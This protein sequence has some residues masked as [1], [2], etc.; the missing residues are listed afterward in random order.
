[1]EWVYTRC[2]ASGN[3]FGVIPRCRVGL[4][5]RYNFGSS[6]SSLVSA[7]HVWPLQEPHC[8]AQIGGLSA[9]KLI[10]FDAAGLLHDLHVGSEIVKWETE[11][12]PKKQLCDRLD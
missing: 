5:L 12:E 6:I 1:M 7:R 8:Y 4:E 10:S 11:T 2:A 3:K 9:G